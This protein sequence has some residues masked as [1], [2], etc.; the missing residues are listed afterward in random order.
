MVWTAKGP[1]PQRNA[2][3][4]PMSDVSGLVSGCCQALAYS[5]DWTFYLPTAHPPHPALFAGFSNRLCVC[6][7][8]RRMADFYVGP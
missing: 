1:A 8:G 5:R 7:S 4:D 6:R 2:P 3:R